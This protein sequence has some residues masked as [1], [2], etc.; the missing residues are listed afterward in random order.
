ML[1]TQKG[2]FCHGWRGIY[3][4]YEEVVCDRKQDNSLL[5][6][7]IF[8]LLCPHEIVRG[9]YVLPQSVCLSVFTS[10]ALL[11]VV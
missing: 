2:Y 3:G 4:I 8:F 11:K 1:D 6:Q 9:H 7:V 10:I 5:E